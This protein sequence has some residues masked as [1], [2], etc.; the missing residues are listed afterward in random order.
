MDLHFVWQLESVQQSHCC[1]DCKLHPDGGGLT[2]PMHVNP[3]ELHVPEHVHSQH[4]TLN[5][6]FE[7]QQLLSGVSICPETV[8]S[9]DLYLLLLHA[10]AQAD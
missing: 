4:F 6:L 10:D 5:S 3:S 1:P 8:P 7:H 9:L 2:E